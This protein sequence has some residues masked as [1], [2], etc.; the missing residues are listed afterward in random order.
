[1]GAAPADVLEHSKH[2]QNG[3]G[4]EQGWDADAAEF[5]EQLGTPADQSM[6]PIGRSVTTLPVTAMRDLLGCEFCEQ[7]PAGSLPQ[8][9]GTTLPHAGSV[10]A[11][12]PVGT[13]VRQQMRA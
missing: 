6:A 13:A 11:G 10:H 4:A 8:A 2:F 5:R 9:A 1:M 3:S 12:L 7:W